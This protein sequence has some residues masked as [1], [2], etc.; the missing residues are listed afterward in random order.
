MIIRQRNK[1]IDSYVNS[2]DKKE[3]YEL[4]EVNKALLNM[5]AGLVSKEDKPAIHVVVNRKEY[6][7]SLK[8]IKKH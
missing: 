3:A 6:V 1:L 7:K 4:T 2:E 5:C 8:Q